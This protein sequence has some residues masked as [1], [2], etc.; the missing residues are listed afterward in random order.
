ME[1][2]RKQS[3]YTALTK[4]KLKIFGKTCSKKARKKY[5]INRALHD[6]SAK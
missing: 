2:S 5:N 3:L 1:N 6:A 4:Q